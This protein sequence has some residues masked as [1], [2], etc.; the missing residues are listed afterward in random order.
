MANP[1]SFRCADRTIAPVPAKLASHSDP[2]TRSSTE[3]RRGRH[4]ASS[5]PPTLAQTKNTRMKQRR[6]NRLQRYACFKVKRV[7]QVTKLK[8]W[9]LKRLSDEA[10]DSCCRF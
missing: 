8:V 9:A 2:S 7:E 5:I 3:I 4:N 1:S 6:D 10:G